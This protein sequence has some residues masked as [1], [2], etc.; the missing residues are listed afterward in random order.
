MVAKMNKLA[1]SFSIYILEEGSWC[2]GTLCATSH[3]VAYLGDVD[4]SGGML[5]V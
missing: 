3:M 4:C 5:L 1:A 2:F